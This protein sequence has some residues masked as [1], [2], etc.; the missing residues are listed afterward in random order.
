MTMA[1]FTTKSQVLQDLAAHGTTGALAG[2]AYGT[3]YP[4]ALLRELCA[5]GLAERYQDGRYVRYRLTPRG[6]RAARQS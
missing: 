4:R 1:V 3:L 2:P 6:V 5:V